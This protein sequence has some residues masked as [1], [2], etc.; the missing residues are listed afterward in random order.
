M[1]EIVDSEQPG[2]PRF[3][4]RIL[5]Y[6]Y[7]IDHEGRELLA[8]HLHPHVERAPEPHL[9][10]R[11]DQLGPVLGGAHFPTAE[12]TPAGF[13]RFA[14]REL[15]IEPLRPDWQVALQEQEP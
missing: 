8:F 3:D 14:I 1:Y 6:H 2:R 10:L 15:G 5:T 11:R 4:A 7:S 9:H 13:V 12:M